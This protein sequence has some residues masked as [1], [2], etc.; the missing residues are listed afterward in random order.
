MSSCTDAENAIDAYYGESNLTVVVRG[1]KG[2]IDADFLHCKDAWWIARCYVRPGLRE[3]GLGS[4]M[5]EHLCAELDRRGARAILVPNPYDD[6]IDLDR[7][8]AFYER[9]GFVL[10]VDEEGEIWVRECRSSSEHDQ[11]AR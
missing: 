1:R 4:W 7:L 3:G 5:M 2:V 11:E 9:F 8:I 10:S 6:T